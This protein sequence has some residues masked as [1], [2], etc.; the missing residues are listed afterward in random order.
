[1]L[2]TS[3]SN[4]TERI[5]DER[6]STVLL[7]H[8]E[9]PLHTVGIARWLHATSDLRGI[10]R[11]HDSRRTFWR[12]V[13]REWRRGGA[14]AM[15]DI[16]AFRVYYRL[17]RASHDAAW[18]RATLDAL[19]SEWPAVPADIP[20]L[21]TSRPNGTECEA[22]IRRCAPDA[23]VA[24]CKHILQPR[25]FEIPRAGTL[26]FHDGIAPEYR[27][28]HGCFWAMA[29]GDFDRVGL[30]VLRAD[31]GVDTGPIFGYFRCAFDAAR[32]SYVEISSRVLLD[33]LAEITDLLR[34]I[35]TGEATPI[36]TNGKTSAV[37]GQPR[38]TA[39]LKLKRRL[40]QRRA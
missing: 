16:V 10:V 12:R 3:P 8:A 31:R 28:A 21:D 17:E 6:I 5:V 13:K 4:C 34:R 2:G 22:F 40:K 39:Y 14:M 18:E 37:W 15:L 38:L 36:P 35:V 23:V 33:N 7:C 25:I 20:V 30:T 1:L 11:V 29:T 32:E 24:L 27:N 19:T 9:E 26:I